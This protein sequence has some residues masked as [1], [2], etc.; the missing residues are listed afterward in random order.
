[1][2]FSH[3]GR[4]GLLAIAFSFPERRLFS[5]LDN[6]M[7]RGQGGAESQ[8]RPAGRRPV[9]GLALGG[10][11]ARG[12]AHVGIVRTLMAHGIVPDVVVGTSI[13]AVVGGAYAAG[14]LDTLEAWARRLQPRS[15]LSYLD[16][17]LNGSGLIGGDK[18]AAELEAAIGSTLIEDLPLKFA[19]VTTEVRTGHET[20]VTHGRM[21]DAM[22][23]S[24]ALPGIFAPV[25]IGG[26]WLVDGALVNPVPVSVCR[27]L[28]A[29][30]TIAVNLNADVFGPAPA[31]EDA[32]ELEQRNVAEEGGRLGFLRDYFRRRNGTPST[33][34]VLAR[35][36]HIVQDRI[37]RARLAADPPDVMIAPRLGHIGYLEFHRAEEC[38]A[39]GEEAARQ[40][41]PRIRE[42][43]RLLEAGGAAWN[44]NARPRSSETTVEAAT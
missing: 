17:R 37:S 38:I 28:G 9:I 14:H 40:A 19:T 32:L 2:L 20:W 21:V 44:P 13:G 25:L 12:F 10:G 24:Y 11:A 31:G 43:I 5:V 39:A 7:G 6:W 8:D 41:L 42:A 33:F 15:V 27:A 16:L 26:R 1:M 36:L 23:A 3:S 35:S 22:R 29:E 18:L 4:S 34:S 30:L